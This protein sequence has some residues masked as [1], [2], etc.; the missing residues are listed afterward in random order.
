MAQV[1]SPVPIR[2]TTYTTVGTLFQNIKVTAPLMLNPGPVNLRHDATETKQC[3]FV[4]NIA[5]IFSLIF[6]I[7]RRTTSFILRNPQS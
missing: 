6:E 1:Y 7:S 3:M 2:Q 4:L 5:F